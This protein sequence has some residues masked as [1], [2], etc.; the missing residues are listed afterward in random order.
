MTTKI[1]WS[2]SLVGFLTTVSSA[3]LPLNESMS[4]LG[5]GSLVLLAGTIV[6]RLAKQEE[7][8]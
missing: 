8:H 7:E 1:G 6:I 3:W 4:L 5:L 2:L